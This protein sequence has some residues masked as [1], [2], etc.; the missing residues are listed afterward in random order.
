MIRSLLRREPDERITS[1]DIL[2][3]PWM[4]R[5]CDESR[6]FVKSASDQCV[7][8]IYLDSA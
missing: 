6:D 1:D 7:P 5:D 2:L 3:H 8:D 4:T